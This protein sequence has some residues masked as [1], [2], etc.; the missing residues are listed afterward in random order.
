MKHLKLTFLLTVLISMV[1]TRLFA[2]HTKIDG[3][4]YNI[5]KEGAIVTF[6]TYLESWH[7]YE[8]DYTGSIIIPDSVMYYGERSTHGKNSSKC[9]LVR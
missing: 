9:I 1:G 3:I 2:Y 4:Y 8:S 7:K 5:T 6:Q